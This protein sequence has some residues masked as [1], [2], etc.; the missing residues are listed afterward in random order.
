MLS[1]K[2]IYDAGARNFRFE[3]KQKEILR[4]KKNYQPTPSAS[5]ILKAFSSD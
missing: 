5:C 4:T 1:I 2:M 3:G